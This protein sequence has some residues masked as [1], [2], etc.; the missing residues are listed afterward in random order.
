MSTFR[1]GVASADPLPD[2]V[3]LWTRVTTD[4]GGPVPVDWWAGVTPDEVVGVGV[5]FT[6]N[7]VSYQAVV[8]APLGGIHRAVARDGCCAFRSQHPS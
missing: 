2:G 4:A 6:L 3:L 7:A 5:A 8:L 1:H